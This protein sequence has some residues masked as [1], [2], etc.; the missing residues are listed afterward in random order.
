MKHSFY[1]PPFLTEGRKLGK[2]KRGL[3]VGIPDKGYRGTQI[4]ILYQGRTVLVEDWD[5]AEVFKLHIDKANR[6]YVNYAYF[7]WPEERGV[8]KPQQTSLDFD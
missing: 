8:Q 1:T 2:G 6:C 4:Y 5:K 7:R 3:Y